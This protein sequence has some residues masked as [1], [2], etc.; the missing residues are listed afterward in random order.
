MREEGFAFRKAEEA[1]RIR[2]ACPVLGAIITEAGG[3]GAR[4]SKVNEAVRY[5]VPHEWGEKLGGDVRGQ[6]RNWV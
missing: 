5:D 4:R 3:G 6:Q 2:S 1:I